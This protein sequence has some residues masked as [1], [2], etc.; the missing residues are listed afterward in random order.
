MELIMFIARG[1]VIYNL[2]DYGAGV[3]HWI[4]SWP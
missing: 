1:T 4:L 3:I 2:K